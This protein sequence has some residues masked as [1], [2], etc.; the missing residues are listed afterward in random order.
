MWKSTVLPVRP[1]HSYFRGHKNTADATPNIACHKTGTGT[2]QLLHSPPLSCCQ[3]VRTT[4]ESRPCSTFAK[5][6]TFRVVSC[7][8]LRSPSLTPPGPSHW[9]T[10]AGTWLRSALKPL[11]APTAISAHPRGSFSPF[12]VTAL[13]E[14]RCLARNLLHQATCLLRCLLKPS[15][16]CGVSS[17]GQSLIQATI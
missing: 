8:I 14:R 12:Q 15:R 3:Q 4:T 17:E 13:T 6:G 11:A 5:N 10:A 1:H 7:E 2:N 9:F 16:S